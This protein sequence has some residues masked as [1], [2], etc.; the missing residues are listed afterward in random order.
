MRLFRRDV[1]SS[2][3]PS[4][5]MRR[6]KSAEGRDMVLYPQV[7]VV[8]QAF[9]SSFV[10]QIYTP[11]LPAPRLVVRIK[12]TN[13]CKTSGQ[14]AGEELRSYRDLWLLILEN[15]GQ[16]SDKWSIQG[17]QGRVCDKLCEYMQWV[18]GQW[19]M[20]RSEWINMENPQTRN[21]SVFKYNI[22]A[23]LISYKKSWKQ[24]LVD[25]IS[26]PSKF[27]V[28]IPLTQQFQC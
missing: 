10:K 3:V 27:I 18:S 26:V 8:C 5:W 12:W 14:T 6:S 22:L 25:L 19:G 13:M 15:I 28:H 9:V 4:K 21:F 7:C 2:P 23:N 1:L 16:T 24:T 20:K 17:T 11:L